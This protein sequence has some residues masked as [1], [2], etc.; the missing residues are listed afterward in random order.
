MPTI[1]DFD[2]ESFEHYQNEPFR[3]GIDW[4][5]IFRHFPRYLPEGVSPIVPFPNPIMLG[6]AFAIDRKFFMEELDGYDREYRIWNGENF[7][8]E[9]FHV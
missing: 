5:L 8:N 3:A 2:S 1:D 7:Y 4:L 9:I 6:C